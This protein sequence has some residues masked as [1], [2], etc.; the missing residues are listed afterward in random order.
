MWWCKLNRAVVVLVPRRCRQGQAEAEC[1]TVID[2]AGAGASGLGNFPAVRRVEERYPQEMAP[3]T[4]VL[5]G[6][7]AAAAASFPL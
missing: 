4:C 2:L 3:R 6:K 1:G 5:Y 7:V